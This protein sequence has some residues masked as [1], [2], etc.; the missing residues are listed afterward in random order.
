MGRIRERIGNGDDMNVVV[1]FPGIGT[2]KLK[3]KHA[4]LTRA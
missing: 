1:A 2:K 4:Q 3:V